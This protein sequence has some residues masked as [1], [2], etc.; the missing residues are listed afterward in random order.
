M[1]KE[2]F[3]KVIEFYNYI[4]DIYNFRVYKVEMT[5]E[6]DGKAKI[7]T[8]NLFWNKEKKYFIS[9]GLP[10]EH[11]VN[12]TKNYKTIPNKVKGISKILYR[13]KYNFRNRKYVCLSSDQFIN[14]PNKKSSDLKFQLP[15]K[16]VHLLDEDDSIIR[17]V[18]KKFMKIYGP[19][20][21]FHN[22]LTPRVYD[23]FF[24]DDYSKIKITNILNQSKT[25]SKNVTLEF[26]QQEKI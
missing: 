18:T 1:F 12:V 5:Y 21:D 15:I 13:I 2:L 23:L 19:N 10:D 26:L 16:D 11:W 20:N 6:Y 22:S 14:L 7:K 9:H 25:F 8:K 24:Y 4:F 17:D 3:L